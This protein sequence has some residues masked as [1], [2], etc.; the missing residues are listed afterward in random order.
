MAEKRDRIQG[1]D[2]A[3][4]R[5]VF[6]FRQASTLN[7]LFSAK[8]KISVG[9]KSE[10]LWLNE[11]SGSGKSMITIEEAGKALHPSEVA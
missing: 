5:R 3:L 10:V 9:K 1:K 4:N 6:C 8:K 11:M 7:V 2:W